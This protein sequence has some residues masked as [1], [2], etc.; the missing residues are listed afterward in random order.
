M[1]HFALDSLFKNGYYT[2]ALRGGSLRFLTIWL[3]AIG[4]SAFWL[5]RDDDWR[6]GGLRRAG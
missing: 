5:K 1:Y 6:R 4:D 3:L 2:T